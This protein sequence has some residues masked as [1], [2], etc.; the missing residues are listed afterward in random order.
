MGPDERSSEQ[1]GEASPLSLVTES[2]S[3]PALRAEGPVRYITVSGD[4]DTGG[5]GIVGAFWISLDG[6]RGG[7]LV[8]PNALFTGS[9]MVKGFRGALRR[10]W[11]EDQIYRYWQGKAGRVDAGVKVERQQYAESLWRLHRM[12]QDQ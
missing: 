2:V 4:R 3:L 1:W 6:K 5:W 8:N 10:G 11:T 12:I 9:E 7:F